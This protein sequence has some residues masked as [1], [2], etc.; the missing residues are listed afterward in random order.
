MSDLIKAWASTL[1]VILAAACCLGLPLLLSA[2]SL[3]LLIHDAIL[4]P[5]LIA[6]VAVNPWL[7]WRTTGRHH[8]RRPFGLGVV[9]G[10]LAMVGLYLHPAVTALGLLGRVA[11]SARDF[12]NGQRAFA[13]SI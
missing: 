6:F 10:V 11:A 13:C 8:G 7:L 3:G 12:V 9:G 5:L 2:A 4:I 1:G